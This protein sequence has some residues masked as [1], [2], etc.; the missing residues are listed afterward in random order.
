MRKRHISAGALILF[1]AAA[2]A[3]VLVS[4]ASDWEPFEVFVILLVI[5]VVSD[6]FPLE[7]RDIR[8]SGSFL[9]IVL[10]AALLGPTPAVVIALATVS[11]D[12]VR[13]RPTLMH[14]AANLATYSTFPLLGGLLVRVMA[15]RVDMQSFYFAFVV[16]GVFMVAIAINFLLIALAVRIASGIELR[17]QTTDAFLPLLRVH[18]ATGLIAAAVAVSYERLG[19][20]ILGLLAVGGL[21]FQILLR[22]T[23]DSMHRGEQLSQR[24]QELASLQ[25]GLL[26]TVLQTLSLRDRM[27]ARHSAAVARY[28]REMARELGLDE[29][30]QDVIHTAGLL[31]DIGKFIFPDSILFA[32]AKLSDEDFR[33]IKM[34]PEQGA[35]LVRRIEGY[36]PVAEIIHAHHERIDGRGYPRGLPPEEIPLGSRLISIAD[37]YDVMTSRDSYRKPVSSEE[38]IAELR[39]VSGTQLDG[40]LV[41]V[42]I[43]LVERRSIAFRHADDA[44]FEKELSFDRRVRDYAQPVLR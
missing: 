6:A 15:S 14:V 33:I 12:T 21:V 40:E 31:H 35:R 36:G 41:E 22:T 34:H 13:T 9:A 20:A 3:T 29:R 1:I 10:A 11:T 37:T 42:F 27:T 23:F 28:S 2:V 26:T 4:R 39:R 44:D 17:K 7:F 18:F 30:E 32:D 16:F 19:V 43:G 8:I 24:T 5:A 25:V 38:A